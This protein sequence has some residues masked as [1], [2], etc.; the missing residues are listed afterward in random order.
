MVLSITLILY[1]PTGLRVL[2][3]QSQEQLTARAAATPLLIGAKGSPLE[4][5]L[6]SL[7]SGAEVPEQMQYGEV[8]KVRETGFA[9][10]IPMYVRY[11]AQQDPIIGTTLDYFGFRGLHIAG[12]QMMTRLG[13]SVLGAEV[14]KRRGISPGESVT[15][16]PESVFDLARAAARGGATRPGCRA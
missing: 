9:D 6:N 13:D 5:V 2:V 3:H 4:L 10:P 12:G 14:A 15:S 8:A 16:S 1:I 7:Y 11:H